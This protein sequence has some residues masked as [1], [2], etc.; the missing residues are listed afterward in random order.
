MFYKRNLFGYNND[1]RKTET[2]ETWGDACSSILLTLQFYTRSPNRFLY[3]IC[4][5]NNI[6]KSK[7]FNIVLPS[8][9]YDVNIK[10]NN[11]TNR[12]ISFYRLISIS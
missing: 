5:Y 6:E 11:D 1:F 9:L 4:F 2:T 7:Y 3:T 12:L 8:Q 10:K